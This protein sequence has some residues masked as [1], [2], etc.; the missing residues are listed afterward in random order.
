VAELG[1]GARLDT[2]GF[3]DAQLHD[4]V[5]GLLA[6]GALR[7]RLASAGQAIRA[8]DGAGRAA[9]IIEAAAGD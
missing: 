3:T 5:D 2:Y 8:R 6:D 7:E 1:L 4:A 9:S